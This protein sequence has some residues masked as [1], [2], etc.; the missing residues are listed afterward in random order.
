M[1]AQIV[2]YTPNAI[3][4]STQNS[5]PGILILTDSYD[6]NW[7]VT[8]DGQRADVLRVY[9]ALRGVCLPPGDHHV[10]FE[11]QPRPFYAGVVISAV[12]WLALVVIGVIAAL[13]W[14]RNIIGTG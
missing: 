13:R 5:Q 14:K 12:G 9:T 1:S 4:I 7:V 8:V 6:P 10:R 3:D 2:S 11:F